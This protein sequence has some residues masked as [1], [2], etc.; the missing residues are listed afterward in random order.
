M[1]TSDGWYLIGP[2]I[3]VGLVGFLGAVFW[4]M[5][6]QPTVGADGYADGL[7]IFGE[8]EDYGLLSPAAVTDEPEIADEIRRLLS[9]AGIRATSATRRDGRVCV[10][11]FAEEVEEAR[12]LVGSS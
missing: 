9:A 7:A 3:A 11:V 8:Q 5:G 4:R 2:L 6:L 12:R 10:L 1:A